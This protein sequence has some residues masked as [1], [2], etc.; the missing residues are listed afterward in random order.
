M[1][2]RKP[3][4]GLSHPVAGAGAGRLVGV[5]VVVVVVGAGE[6]SR[7]EQLAAP[8]LELAAAAA[9][10][11][12]STCLVDCTKDPVRIARCNSWILQQPG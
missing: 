8:G 1:R 5:A 10:A 12:D 4:P 2:E 6:L 7:S 3:R 11:V 9:A